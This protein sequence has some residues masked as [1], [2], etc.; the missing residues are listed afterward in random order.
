M[1]ISSGGIDTRPR[2]RQAA[3]G[4]Q[5]E[6]GRRVKGFLPLLVTEGLVEALDRLDI[7]LSLLFH[8][9]LVERL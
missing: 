4:R 1:E 7:L 2:T 6:S 5:M 9:Q 3:F 8:I